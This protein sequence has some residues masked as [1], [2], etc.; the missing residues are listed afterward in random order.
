[1]CDFNI[2]EKALKIAWVNRIQDDSQVSRKIIPNQLLHKHGGFA[3]VTKCNFT[4]SSLD[5]EDKLLPFYKSV[6]LLVRV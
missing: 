6:R 2:M 1:M 4:P 3:F 5:F